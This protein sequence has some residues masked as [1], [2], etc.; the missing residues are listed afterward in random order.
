MGGQC[1]M[2]SAHNGYLPNQ[3]WSAYEEQWDSIHAHAKYQLPCPSKYLNKM[4]D[5][6]GFL[7]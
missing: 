5:I 7:H 1:N 4:P 3:P 2:V 6:N